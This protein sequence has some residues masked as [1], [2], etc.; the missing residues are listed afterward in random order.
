MEA[1]LTGKGENGGQESFTAT[2]VG[3]RIPSHGRRDSYADSGVRPSG[4]ML[5]R[6]M[7]EWPPFVIET[8]ADEPGSGRGW[9]R[10]VFELEDSLTEKEAEPAPRI[11]EIP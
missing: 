3:F 7:D 11:P 5:A 2:L 8:P 10:V 6:R 1:E 4:C 9:E